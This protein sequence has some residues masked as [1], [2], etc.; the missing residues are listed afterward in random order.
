MRCDHQPPMGRQHTPDGLLGL[1]LRARMAH[2][3][4]ALLPRGSVAMTRRALIT[5][6]Q[7]WTD[8]ATIHTVLRKVWGERTAVL[9]TGWCP[10]GKGPP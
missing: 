3:R 7:A 9:V 6:S 5:G 10:E 2:H 1:P 8:T 4:R